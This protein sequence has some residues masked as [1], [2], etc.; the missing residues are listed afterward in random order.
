[1]DVARLQHGIEPPNLVK[2]ELQLERALGGEKTE[3]GLSL[4][5]LACAEARLTC[6]SFHVS[7]GDTEAAETEDITPE[8]KAL[9]RSM[10]M[11]EHLAD[12][13]DDLGRSVLVLSFC[14]AVSLLLVFE[15]TL[16]RQNFF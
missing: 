3:N 13:R 15:L 14:P 8:I 7:L 9:L 16:S 6:S 1:M 4:S 11:D 2:M 10:R 5:N 12:Q